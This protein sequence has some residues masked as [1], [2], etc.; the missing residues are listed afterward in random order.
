MPTAAESPADAPA[1][2]PRIRHDKK[3]R[4]ALHCAAKPGKF[5]GLADTP[6]P[7]ET[8]PNLSGCGGNVLEVVSQP[9]I[10]LPLIYATRTIFADGRAVAKDLPAA[11][12]SQALAQGRTTF[13][14]EAPGDGGD[15]MGLKNRRALARSPSSVSIAQHLLA[16]SARLGRTRGMAP[17]MA[18]FRCRVG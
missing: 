14:G 16:T 18:H 17:G 6:A 1:M 7:A 2:K 4:F 3:Q 10:I 9:R 8:H 12:G 15:F 13:C 5:P 11:P